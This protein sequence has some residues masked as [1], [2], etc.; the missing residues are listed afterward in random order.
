MIGNQTTH[1]L[2]SCLDSWLPAIEYVQ[3]IVIFERQFWSHPTWSVSL[4][5]GELRAG[6]SQDRITL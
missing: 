2:K 3:Y 4:R 6:D 5:A 1:L